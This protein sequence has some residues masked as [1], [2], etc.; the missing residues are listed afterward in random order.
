LQAAYT[1]YKA[2]PAG[3]T[4]A[5]VAVQAAITAANTFLQANGLPALLATPAAKAM[6]ASVVRP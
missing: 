4:T 5:Q 2:A 3:S 1:T 6:H